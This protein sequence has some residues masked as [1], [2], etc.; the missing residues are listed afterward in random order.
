MSQTEPEQ[1]ASPP[2]FAEELLG[3]TL[4]DVVTEDDVSG[5]PE[6]FA[7]G[8]AMNEGIPDAPDEEPS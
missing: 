3:P 8:D 5:T 1:L 4:G 6:A 7:A 2:S